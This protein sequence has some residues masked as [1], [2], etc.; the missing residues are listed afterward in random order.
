MPQ[1]HR[2]Y[3]NGEW[4]PSVSG[5]T[6]PSHNP[7]D[8]RQSVGLFQKSVA[9]DVQRAAAAASGALPAWR[10]MPTPQCG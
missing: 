5:R 2:N 6:F 1:T 8:F 4:T 7:A 10:R 9:E 3:V